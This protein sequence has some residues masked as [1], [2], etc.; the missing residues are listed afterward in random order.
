MLWDHR[1]R[2]DADAIGLKEKAL[3]RSDSAPR[4]Q[5]AIPRASPQSEIGFRVVGDLSIDDSAVGLWRILHD[6]CEV[7]VYGEEAAIESL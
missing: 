4:G 6:I 5:Q 7:A 3:P 1:L 2:S